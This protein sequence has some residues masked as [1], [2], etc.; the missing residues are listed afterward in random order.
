MLAE[1]WDAQPQPTTQTVTLGPADVTLGHDDD[2]ADDDGTDVLGHSFG[3]DNEHPKRTVH[4]DQF[5]IEWRPVTNGQFY[6]F[7]TGAGQDKVHFPKSWVE[8]DGEIFVRPLN[9]SLWNCG[10]LTEIISIGPYALRSHPHE[11]RAALAYHYVLRQSVNLCER[12]GRT[13]PDRAG[14]S[15]V[16]R[17]VRMWLRGRCEH[18]VPKLASHPVS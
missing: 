9:M 7:Y 15:F 6:E 10:I 2:E 17:Q 1:S 4:V 8:V 3:W 5:K 14:A 18:R 13:Y 16:L 11:D 12:E